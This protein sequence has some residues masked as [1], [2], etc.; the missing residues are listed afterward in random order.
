[1]AIFNQTKDG[2]N[3]AKRRELEIICLFSDDNKIVERKKSVRP[4]VEIW[5]GLS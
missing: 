4:K 3:N 5:Q 1:M 2:P